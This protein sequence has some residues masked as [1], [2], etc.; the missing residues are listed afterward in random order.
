[1]RLLVVISRATHDPPEVS[2]ASE[3]E[4]GRYVV[5]NVDLEMQLDFP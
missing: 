2:G 3:V 5:W 1:M 4:L